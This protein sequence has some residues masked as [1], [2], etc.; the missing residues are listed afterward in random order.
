MVTL[1]LLIFTQGVGRDVLR[2]DSYPLMSRENLHSLLFPYYLTTQNIIYPLICT[3][4]QDFSVIQLFLPYLTEL[5]YS[6]A[7]KIFMSLFP[8]NKPYI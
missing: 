8:L 1:G 5:L 2:R 3:E 6:M 7:P 4:C